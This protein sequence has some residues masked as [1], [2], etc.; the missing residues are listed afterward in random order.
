[1]HRADQS[2][3]NAHVAATMARAPSPEMRSACSRWGGG[4]VMRDEVLGAG[5]E[6]DFGAAAT[7]LDLRHGQIR[8]EDEPVGTAV[9]DAV[10]V[11]L[12]LEPGDRAAVVEA[13]PEVDGDTHRSALAAKEPQQLALAALVVVI[14]CE[15]V[16]EHQH[17][18]RRGRE[19]GLE[20]VGRRQVPP[21]HGVRLGRRD[22]EVATAIPVELP[23]EHGTCVEAF[24]A[25][26]I[27]GAVARDRARRTDSR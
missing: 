6:V 9:D 2:V 12:H 25:A 4:Q 22:A 5:V 1:M 17:A 7:E 23:G 13:G 16:G 10:A 24:E 27:D 18:A 21:H 11:V 15:A 20:H 14:A 26:P 3:Q 19:P 8:L